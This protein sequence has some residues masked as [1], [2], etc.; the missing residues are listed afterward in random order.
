VT[1]TD[2]D[3]GDQRSTPPLVEITM[4][5]GFQL[6]IGGHSVAAKALGRRDSMRLAKYLALAPSRRVHR[7]QLIDTLWPEASFDS[8]ANRLHKA[9][10]FL[11]K[12]TDLTDSV[13]LAGDTVALFPNAQVEIDVATFD[14]LALD[15]LAN[16]NPRSI[17]RAIAIYAGDLLPYDL[18]DDW[19]VQHRQRLHQRFR[20]LLR[21]SGQFERLITVDPTDEDGHLEV[22]RAMLRAGD[23]SGVLRQFALLSRVLE[24]ELGVGPGPEACSLRDLAL[25]REGSDLSSF[26]PTFHTDTSEPPRMSCASSRP[27]TSPRSSPRPATSSA[28]ATATRSARHGGN[29]HRRCRA[30]TR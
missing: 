4:L 5:G 16:G 9:A 19:V 7:E 30:N 15:G 11:R 21:T 3:R 25:V 27:A 28:V 29:G 8:V 26:I 1:G 18:Y 17:A 6:V 13:V 12:A 20:E 2:T 23:R 24:Q 10:H 22:M 14:Q